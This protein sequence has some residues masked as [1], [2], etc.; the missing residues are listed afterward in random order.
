MR[1]V[2]CIW[3]AGELLDGIHY[4]PQDD[5]EKKQNVEKVL[6]FVSSKRIRMPQTSARG[7]L[8]SRLLITFKLIGLLISFSLSSKTLWRGTLNPP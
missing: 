7:G 1:C 4:V 5:Q 2:L 6:Q 3:Q 8:Q